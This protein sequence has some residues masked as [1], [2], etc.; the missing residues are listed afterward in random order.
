MSSAGCDLPVWGLPDTIG[1]IAAQPIAQWLSP[2]SVGRGGVATVEG[3]ISG[4]FLSGFRGRPKRAA[5]SYVLTTPRTRR[6]A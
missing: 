3:R 5:E 1:S 2:P 6:C 4:T